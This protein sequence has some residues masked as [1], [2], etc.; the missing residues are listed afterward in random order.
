MLHIS[1]NRDARRTY[2]KQIYYA[3]RQKILSGELLSGEALPPYRKLSQELGIS[4]NTVLSAYDMLVADGVLR[5]IAGSGFYVEEGMKRR[6]PVCL[7]AEYQTADMSALIIP[8]GTVNFDSGQP[9]LELFPRAGWN[10]AVSA[11]MMDIP[12]AA[13]G[14]DIPQGR[15]EL[16]QALCEYLRRSQGVYCKPERLIVTSGA[17]QAV[18]LAAELLLSGGKE[19]WIEDP[20]PA[21][22]RHMLAYHTDNIAA[23]PVDDHGVDP[24]DFPAGR[25]PG[26][27]IV[28][29][30]RQ[31]PT[32]AVMPMK[33]RM[34]LVEY[35]ENAG[36]FILED[37]FESEFNYDT[38]PASSLYEL[39][40]ERVISV[41]TFSKV[42][43]PSVRL[44]YMA[45]PAELLSALC[46][47]KRLS[48]HHTNPVYQMALATFINEGILEKHIRRMK[49]EY[50]SRRDYLISCLHQTFGAGIHISGGA[51]GMNL[52]VLFDDVMFTDEKIQRMLQCGVYAV[53]VERRGKYTNELIL[54]Y[55]GL[56]KE[57]IA[58]G[59]KR[60][61]KS[62]RIQR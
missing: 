60:L 59:V 40:P 35:A 34:A 54:R 20:A 52:V 44:G 53:P 41:G 9:A 49:R 17:K 43:Y 12:A 10:R 23:F 16:R 29:P 37:N 8:E 39:A 25:S 51:S 56:T 24:A 11:A 28:S 57:E 26:L 4:K 33:R 47:C 22:L 19:V 32:G 2:T 18:T 30:A 42:L 31:F 61:A 36:A 50:R 45:V 5:S 3:I 46:E 55:A 58:L 38:P 48:D 15:P 13:L 7:P 14:Y 21:L 62:I 1:L 6:E 27:I